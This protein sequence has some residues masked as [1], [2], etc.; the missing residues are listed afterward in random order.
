MGV[1]FTEI[2]KYGAESVLI[3]HL[4]IGEGFEGWKSE[5]VDSLK[6]FGRENGCRKLEAFCRPGLARQLK[7]LGFKRKRVEVRLEWGR[8]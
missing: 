7:P 6:A 4:L 3:A 8:H 1:A 2:R 5:C